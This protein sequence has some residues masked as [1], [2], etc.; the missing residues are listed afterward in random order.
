MFGI[1]FNGGEKM[2]WFKNQF[3]SVIEWKG[4]TR[5]T[6]VYR[7]PMDGEIMKKSKVVVREGQVAIFVFEGKL[8]DILKPGTHTL[9]EGNI[10]VLTSLQSWKY[11]FESPIK[12][13]VY[14]VNMIQFTGEKWG[15]QN[16][17]IMRDAEFGMVRVRGFGTFSF[18]IGDVK[19][20]LGELLATSKSFQVSDIVG[21]LKSILVSGIS[22]TIAE[23]KIPILDVAANTLEFNE[24]IKKVISIKFEGIG[25]I[26]AEFFIENISV[27]EEVEKMLDTRTS[28]GIMGDKMS[29]FAQYQAS[30]AMRDAAQNEGSGLAGAGVGLGAGMGMANMFTGAMGGM[31]NP[32]QQQQ[33]PQQ[34][35]P[36]RATVEK[37]CGECGEGNSSHAKF[38]CGCGNAIKSSFCSECGEENEND[39]KFCNNCGKKL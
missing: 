12:A 36:A 23:A 22:D 13:E 35:A 5:D 32:Q 6:M 34:S 9:N 21:Y 20:F 26:L 30:L 29:Q 14:F 38:C 37:K 25:L 16:P 31:M 39:A 3:L 10:P 33:Q 27:P 24:A 8:T 4:E 28:M 17:I 19:I 1:K 11:F 18:R 2:G 15:T 7:Y